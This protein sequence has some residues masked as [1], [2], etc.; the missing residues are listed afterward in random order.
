MDALFNNPLLLFL[1][2]VVGLCAVAIGAWH[3][4]G[5]SLQNRLKGP[6]SMKALIIKKEPKLEEI[7]L[8]IDS[9]R[10]LVHKKVHR[11]WYLFPQAIQ[12][13]ESG[14]IA[15]VLLTN[16]SCIPQFPGMDIDMGKLCA[17]IE[18]NDPYMCNDR[19]LADIE[20]MHY[21]SQNSALGE[22]LGFAALAAVGGILVVAII[23]LIPNL[24]EIF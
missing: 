7:K 2:I 17:S 22:W 19:C 13:T 18:A 1:M 6:E 15:G 20:K 4:F 12:R 11:A 16:E 10:Y 5:S 21:E 8:E 3:F 24:K 9:S 14:E 23:T